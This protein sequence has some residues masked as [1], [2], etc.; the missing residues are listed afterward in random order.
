MPSPP[1]LQ[2][3]TTQLSRAPG[4]GHPSTATAMQEHQDRVGATCG[5]PWGAQ[6]YLHRQ[7]VQLYNFL[8]T[9]TAVASP[10]GSPASQSGW[11]PDQ[12]PST[13]STWVYTVIFT[14]LSSVYSLMNHRRPAHQLGSAIPSQCQVTLATTW[15]PWEGVTEELRVLPGPCGQPQPSPQGPQLQD[16]KG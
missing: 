10:T 9:P 4:S 15:E 6:G 3:R 1:A 13:S 14:L 5:T 2:V 8:S 12:N 11:G 7:P 16:G